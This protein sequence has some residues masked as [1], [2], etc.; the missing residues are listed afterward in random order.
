MN[1]D[2]SE[3]LF[4]AP[5]PAV[6]V[7]FLIVAG[8]ALQTFSGGD[9]LVLRWGYSPALTPQNGHWETLATAMFLHGGWPHALMNG[10]FGLAFS[11]PVVRAFGVRGTGLAAFVSL[12]LVTGVA[13]NVG[14]G[15]LHPT[16]V[17]PLIGASGAVS[18]LAAAAARIVAGGGRVGPLLSPFVV[19]MGG[20][21]LITNLLTAV[22]GFAP[23][24]GGATVAWEAHLVGFAVG[25][26]L[27]KPLAALANSGIAD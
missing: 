2:Q 3:P 18:G 12:F 7:G 4:N 11:T 5:W 6:A 8:Y 23:G 21:W 24:A 25:L 9:A 17:A 13:G 10:A 15:V 20:G 27:V 1:Q 26:F 16:E 19:G 22:L 14:F